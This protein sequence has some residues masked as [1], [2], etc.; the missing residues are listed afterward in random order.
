MTLLL[1]CLAVLATARL[2]ELAVSVR[3]WRHHRQTATMPGEAL[4]PWMVALHSSVFF[5]L[6]LEYSLFG[7]AF[8]SPVS[9]VATGLVGFTLLLRVWTLKTIGRSWNVRVV[10]GPNY[11]I[12]ATGPYRY[13]RHP[14]YLVVILELCLI[15]LM[16][17]LWRSAVILSLLNGLILRRRI[18][19][20]EALLAQNSSWVE[21]MAHK[22]RFFPF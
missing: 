14:N 9:L 15:P 17:E 20:E 2:I 7:G 3:N 21:S 10:G 13:I 16:W 8:A 18:A 6:P 5:L 1:E 4:F 22:P 19:N 11:P 12:V